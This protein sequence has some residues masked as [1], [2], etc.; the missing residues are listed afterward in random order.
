M[1]MKKLNKKVVAD[2]SLDPSKGITLEQAVN[3]FTTVWDIYEDDHFFQDYRSKKGHEWAD[4]DL[5]SLLVMLTRKS[6]AGG[7]VSIN[8]Y[9]QIARNHKSSY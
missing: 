9:L 2:G 8:G 6:K 5:K 4:E 7:S 3:W 1:G